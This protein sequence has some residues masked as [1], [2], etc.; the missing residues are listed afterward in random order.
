MNI[1]YF[2]HYKWYRNHPELK[3][4]D[5][6]LISIL[7]D[8]WLY[9][10]RKA[11][12]YPLKE[13]SKD[14]GYSTSDNGA[15][16]ASRETLKNMG[17]VDWD[18]KLE[19]TLKK[20]YYTINEEMLDKLSNEPYTSTPVVTKKEET[21]STPPAKEQPKVPLTPG[22]F[23]DYLLKMFDKHRGYLMSSDNMKSQA[24]LDKLYDVVLTKECV[25]LFGSQNNYNSNF[26]KL[27]RIWYQRQNDLK[28]QAT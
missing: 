1:P 8:A 4:G 21:V 18:V 25:E 28:S 26:Y 22:E 19:G 6:I 23:N 10:K 9:H 24:A 17:I 13:L 12:T 5:R 2:K 27:Y 11:F 20:C 15:I 16:I 7:V 3:P 14:V